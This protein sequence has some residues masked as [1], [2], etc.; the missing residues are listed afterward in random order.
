MLQLAQILATRLIRIILGE[1]PALLCLSY[2]LL[3][4]IACHP[5]L[6][7]HTGCGCL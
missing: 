1:V 2:L 3:V 4:S 7:T 6:A 5:R